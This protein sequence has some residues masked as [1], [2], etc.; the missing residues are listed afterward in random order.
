MYIILPAKQVRFETIFKFIAF[1]DAYMSLFFLY[2]FLLKT[3]CSLSTHREEPTV[4][5]SILRA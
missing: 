1:P 4:Y 5:T 3:I 2:G